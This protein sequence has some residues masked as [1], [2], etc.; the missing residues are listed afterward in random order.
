MLWVDLE[1]SRCPRGAQC[2]WQGEA[3]VHLEVWKLDGERERLRLSTKTDDDRQTE[4]DGTTIR[5]VDVHPYPGEFED[6][7]RSDY[8]AMLEISE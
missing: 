3:V 8:E 6:V 1:D 4:I 7:E 2:I 5:L